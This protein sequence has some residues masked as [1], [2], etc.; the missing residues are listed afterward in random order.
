MRDVDKYNTWYREFNSFLKEGV[1]SDYAHKNELARLLRFESSFGKKGEF[2]S[3]DDY[4]ARM[5]PTQT[6]IY[7]LCVPTRESGEASPYYEAHRANGTEV[8]FLY[9]S[10]DEFVMKNLKTYGKRKLVSCESMPQPVDS[11]ETAAERAAKEAENQ[12]LIA[13]VKKVLGPKVA[14]VVVSTRLV[15]SPALIV[16]HESSAMRKMIKMID[17]SLLENQAAQKLKLEINPNHPIFK[18]VIAAR[19]A[20]PLVANAVVEQVFDNALL[21]ADILDNPRTMLPRMHALLEAALNGTAGAATDATV[22]PASTSAASASAGASEKSAET[23]E[24]QA[25]RERKAAAAKVSPKTQEQ[26]MEDFL[27]KAAAEA[28]AYEAA[29]KAKDSA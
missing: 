17:Q 26:M 18:K 2:V 16:D 10:M 7:Y 29:R 22:F 11:A 3:L 20:N 27:K 4:I 6:E 5:P 8:L 19:A 23:L 28:E 15:S 25:E 1:C 13:Y 12:D 21:A 9:L 14:S 24:E